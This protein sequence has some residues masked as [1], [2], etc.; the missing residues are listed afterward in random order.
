M[1]C[2]KYVGA[3]NGFVDYMQMHLHV[4]Y[5]LEATPGPFLCPQD[6]DALCPPQGAFNWALQRRSQPAVA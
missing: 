4:I 2:R 3:G 6:S 5:A 1:L